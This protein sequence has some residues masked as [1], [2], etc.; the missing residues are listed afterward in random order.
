MSE[1]TFRNEHEQ[2]TTLKVQRDP[3][4]DTL[5]V[6]DVVGLVHEAMTLTNME[7][8]ALHR[9]LNEALS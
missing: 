3:N 5:I 8:G 1:Y 9:L 4:G 7:V 2:T 6:L